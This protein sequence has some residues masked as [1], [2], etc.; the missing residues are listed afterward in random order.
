MPPFST[1]KASVLYRVLYPFVTSIYEGLFSL[2]TYGTENVPSVGPCMLVAN[3]VSYLDPIPF[4]S[5]LHRDI[6]FLARKSLFSDSFL[7]TK[8]GAKFVEAMHMLLIQRDGSAIEGLR[9]MLKNLSQERCILMFPEA[10]RS[11]DGKIKKAK[12][13]IGLILCRTHIPVVP[14]RIF[15]AYE[16]LSR[17]HT[18]PDLRHSLDIVYGSPLSPADYDPGKA[19]PERYAE[20]SRRI[21]SAIAALKRPHIPCI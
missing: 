6:F 4:G 9:C 20:A 18:L 5:K 1:P 3:H 13:G 16:M 21:M 7:K 14:A 11:P 2:E 15:G 12:E 8:W 19:H 17:Y 10:V